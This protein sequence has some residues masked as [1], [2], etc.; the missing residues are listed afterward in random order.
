M[1]VGNLEKMLRRL[2]G[3]NIEP[4]VDLAS[5]ADGVW[6][7][8]AQLEIVL[9]NLIVNARDAMPRGGRLAIRTGVADV[10]EPRAT[11]N[12][13]VAPGRYVTLTVS[14]TGSGMDAETL[15]RAFEPFF[16]TKGPGE[17]TGLGLSTVYGVVS[18]SGRHI[19]ISSRVGEGTQIC[20]LLPR[21]E[22]AAPEVEPL[23]PTEGPPR[24]TE[25]IALVEDHD[26]VRLL[27]ERVLRGAGYR[28][29]SA[30]DGGQ[31]LELRRGGRPA[32]RPCGAWPVT[33]GDCRPAVSAPPRR[34]PLRCRPRAAG[35]TL[36]YTICSR[37]LPFVSFTYFTTKTIE[38][39]AQKA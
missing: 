33:R 34:T 22:A 32:P 5:G 12:G 37:V 36:A 23:A 25:T 35:Q 16:T 6:A 1:V 39:S 3:E 10:S 18:Q 11:V 21:S 28:V 20:I 9:M 38:T 19:E 8:P 14:D 17:G 31:A 26:S 4:Q 7:D 30:A 27:A 13:E 29:L 24:G 15:G 2:I